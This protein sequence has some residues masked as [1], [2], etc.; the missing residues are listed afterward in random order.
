VP[1]QIYDAR[2]ESPVAIEQIDFV[3]NINLRGTLDLI[4]LCVPHMGM[5]FATKH[6][7]YLLILCSEL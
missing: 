5:R 3:L 1:M 6:D 4:R 7:G 2:S